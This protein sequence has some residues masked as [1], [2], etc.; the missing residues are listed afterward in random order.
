M[1]ESELSEPADSPSKRV[2]IAAGEEI[3]QDN[4]TI[5][6]ETDF[7]QGSSHPVHRPKPRNWTPDTSSRLNAK[8]LSYSK[9]A[10]LVVLN[11]PDP[12]RGIAPNI[13]M[14]YCESLVASLRRVLFVHGCG[15][16]VWSC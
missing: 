7:L 1:D 3:K 14:E 11:L 16:E 4:R 2:R 8:I 13:Y 6:Q 5:P 9:D 10:Q 15:K 12:I